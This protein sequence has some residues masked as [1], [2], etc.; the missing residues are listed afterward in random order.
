MIRIRGAHTQVDTVTYKDIY[1]K[2]VIHITD[3]PSAFISPFLFEG[4]MKETFTWR[5]D[6]YAINAKVGAM[7]VVLRSQCHT[8]LSNQS[9]LKAIYRSHLPLQAFGKN[10]VWEI[11]KNLQSNTRLRYDIQRIT[12]TPNSIKSLKHNKTWQHSASRFLWQLQQSALLEK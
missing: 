11:L 1:R 6:W 5:W 3:P 12:G 10:G 9:Y 8:G 7:L 4:L 2:K